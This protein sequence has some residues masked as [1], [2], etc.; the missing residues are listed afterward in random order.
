MSLNISE[1][2]KILTVYINRPS[3][4]GYGDTN[5]EELS[6]LINSIITLCE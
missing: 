5:F 3:K 4:L 2:R 6:H 1:L